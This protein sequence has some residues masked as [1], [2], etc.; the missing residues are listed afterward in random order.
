M[1]TSGKL[2]ASLTTSELD[3]L[4]S[5]PLE[6]VCE[7]H[8]K[9]PENI[10]DQGTV[11]R[12]FEYLSSPGFGLHLRGKSA[13]TALFSCTGEGLILAEVNSTLKFILPLVVRSFQIELPDYEDRI[14]YFWE[15]G[16][17][18]YQIGESAWLIQGQKPVARNTLFYDVYT[19]LNHLPFEYFN[20]MINTIPGWTHKI[21]KRFKSIFSDQKNFNVIFQQ[22]NDNRNQTQGI[23]APEDKIALTID[24][25]GDGARSA[26]KL[27]TPLIALAELATETEPGV[28]I[29]EEPELFQNPQSLGK[30]LAEVAD[31]IKDKPIQIFIATHSIEVVAQFI[32]LIE[33]Q[34]IK[35]EDL[36][37]IRLNLHEGKL[38]SSA[39][40]HEEIRRWT[41][42]NLDIRVPQG[43]VDSPLRFQFKET[44]DAED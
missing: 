6:R 1:L 2:E 9:S 18:H 28:F 36:L 44:V 12:H 25:Y 15:R 21:A 27:L 38:A 17:T 24:D 14:V 29:W 26:F 23:I 19:T 41:T 8:K 40:N 34:Q 3:L 20:K 30:L 39:F 42:M 4:G 10:Q 37:A 13:K 16:L 5:D 11:D 33:E 31:L 43:E 7:R 35:S 32:R 22:L